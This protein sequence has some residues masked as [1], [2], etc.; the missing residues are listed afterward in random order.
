MCP[1]MQLIQSE[2]TSATQLFSSLKSSKTCVADETALASHP[3]RT[4]L[5]FWRWK[6]FASWNVFWLC[7]LHIRTHW[8][9]IFRSSFLVFHYIS[10][11]I[12]TKYLDQAFW[13]HG[14]MTASQSPKSVT[15]TT[16]E[17]PRK[18]NMIS[19]PFPYKSPILVS[20]P[21]SLRPDSVWSDFLKSFFFIFTFETS[22]KKLPL[23]SKF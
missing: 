15:S 13:F 7:Q 22:F 3:Q 23:V 6:Q 17:S 14:W 19:N 5:K 1:D 8:Y 11:H 12:D 21:L 18:Q 9:Q 4:F 10:G 16:M 20:K 2:D